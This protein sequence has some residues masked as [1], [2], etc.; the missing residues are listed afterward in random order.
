MNYTRY[1]NSLSQ[2]AIKTTIIL[3]ISFTLFNFSAFSEEILTNAVLISHPPSWLTENRVNR[4][5]EHIQNDLEWD[6]RK[7]KVI[8]Y[9]IQ[10]T[11]QN[12]HHFDAS[13]LAVSRKSDNSIHIGPRV[14][15]SNFDSV[16]GHELVHIILFQKYKDAIPKWLEEGLANYVSQHGKVDYTWLSS[17]AE[18]SII[19]LIHPFESNASENQGNPRYHYQAS[20][21]LMEMIASKCSLHELLQLS[22]RK[23]LE[24]YL[25]T[26]CKIPDMDSSF[27]NWIKK[28]KGK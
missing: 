17:Q 15:S 5:A 28:N 8:W 20:T 24:N 2:K 14:I 27:K 22:M 23:K 10:E 19:N 9:N 7:V 3:T 26:F 21:A 4:V 25:E 11:F 12:F 1:F 13:V 16:F 6:I 18:K